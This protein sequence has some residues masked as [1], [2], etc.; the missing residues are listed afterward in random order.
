MAV[1]IVIPSLGESITEV[2]LGRWHRA[3]GD[4]VEKDEILVEIESDKVTQEFPSPAA[5]ALLRNQPHQNRFHY[6]LQAIL[7]SSP[8]CTPRL[9]VERC[10]SRAP[11]S[12]P[13]PGSGGAGAASG[14]PWS[15]PGSMQ[16]P[17]TEVRALFCLARMCESGAHVAPAGHLR[18]P[19]L[20]RAVVGRVPHRERGGRHVWSRV[21]PRNARPTFSNA[22]PSS[23]TPR[24]PSSATRGRSSRRRSSRRLPVLRRRGPNWSTP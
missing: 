8:C 17:S 4:W 1:E 24:T 15:G 11:E 3:E 18:R 22:G 6:R 7:L 5:G 14:K 12:A 9:S 10:C 13:R 2:R 20:R 23:T 19:R 21:L 16:A